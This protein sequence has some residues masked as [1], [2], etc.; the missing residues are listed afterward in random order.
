MKRVT[1]QFFVKAIIALGLLGIVSE[2]SAFGQS[3]AG[4]PAIHPRPLQMPKRATP[5]PLHAQRAIP[6]MQGPA[7]WGQNNASRKPFQMSKITKADKQQLEAAA[8]IG[9]FIDRANP[10]P[11]GISLAPLGKTFTQDEVHGPLQ[12]PANGPKDEYLLDGGDRNFRAYVGDDWKVHGLDV[13][14][15]IGHF[16]T[17]DGRRI[18]TPS[19]QAAIYS[20]R[21]ASVRRISE[22]TR[23]S[24]TSGASSV[25][26]RTETAIEQ[27]DDQLTMASQDIQPSRHKSTQTPFAFADRTRGVN[28]DTV[29]RASSF[30]RGFGSH[31]NI[32]FLKWG[33]FDKNESAR[34]NLGVQGALRWTDNLRVIINNEYANIGLVEEVTAAQGLVVSETEGA[35][36]TL[37]VT[38][39]ASKLAAKS[40]DI[41]EFMIR[42]D[43]VGNQRIG[44]VTI[45]DS[46]T[47]RLEYVPDSAQ[48]ELQASFSTS[49]NEVDS[50]VLRWEIEEPLKIGKGGLI[51][52]KCRVR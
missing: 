51:R 50:L 6:N 18:A 29:T 39:V 49:R 26:D 36:P 12:L 14:D 46:L 21:F 20:P 16:D 38:K 31:E 41:V 42:F 17:L 2:D 8:R 37:R 7:Q 22:V 15:T 48:S 19:N 47:S 27:F 44:N 32:Q 10:I 4:V 34:L 40:G 5:V 30:I 11:I 3:P 43:N 9:P 28:N 33:S 13:E 1:R 45:I 35:N 23:G 25:I 24:L 52:F